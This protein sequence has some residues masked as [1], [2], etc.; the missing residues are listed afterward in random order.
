[1]LHPLPDNLRWMPMPEAAQPRAALWLA[2]RHPSDK[3]AVM[4]QAKVDVVVPAQ[5]IFG[6]QAAELAQPGLMWF[7]SDPSVDRVINTPHAKGAITEDIEA[8]PERATTHI[9]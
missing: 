6:P 3:G 9:D 4:D 8:D 1:M 7:V 2:P 5:I